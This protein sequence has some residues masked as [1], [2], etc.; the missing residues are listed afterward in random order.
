MHFV[1][2]L[3]RA[4]MTKPFVFQKR[5]S[6]PTANVRCDDIV[7]P[8]TRMVGM[9]NTDAEATFA[10]SD[11]DNQMDISRSQSDN[12]R[13]QNRLQRHEEGRKRESEQ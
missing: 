2:G 5:T 10:F 8:D 1:N 3:L 7:E 4:F 12:L 11:G 6:V 13:Q 9:I